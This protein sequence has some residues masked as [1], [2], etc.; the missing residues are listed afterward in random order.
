MN[1]RVSNSPAP[2]NNFRQEYGIFKILFR[3]LS[4]KIILH[5][6]ELFIY[7]FIFIYNQILFNLHY[8]HDL[9]LC[10]IHTISCISYYVYRKRKH[11]V[12]NA[13]SMKMVKEALERHLHLLRWRMTLYGKSICLSRI[14]SSTMSVIV[15]PLW[16]TKS[17]SQTRR[18][19]IVYFSTG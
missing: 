18:L 4:Y 7:F 19:K 10:G 3:K 2:S 15:L 6:S 11:S 8:F 5:W 1:S 14:A 12:F 16:L 17:K 9:K 13:E